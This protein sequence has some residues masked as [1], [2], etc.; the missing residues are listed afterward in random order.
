LFIVVERSENYVYEENTQ[1]TQL[2]GQELSDMSRGHIRI[3]KGEWLFRLW[4]G[5][6]GLVI[7]GQQLA[8]TRLA[9]S[10]YIQLEFLGSHFIQ[11]SPKI[12]ITRLLG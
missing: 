2:S 4:T 11:N 12:Y 10:K 7:K 3:L 9:F 1:P 5:L 6:I 8:P